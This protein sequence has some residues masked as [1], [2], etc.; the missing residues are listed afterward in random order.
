[1]TTRLKLVPMKYFLLLLITLL[2]ACD[3]SIDS[4]PLPYSADAP[5]SGAEAEDIFDYAYP[6]VLMQVTQDLMF[7][8]PFRPDSHPNQFIM[9]DELAK[10]KNQAVVLG[11]RNTLYFVGWVNLNKGLVAFEIPNMGSRTM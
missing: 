2:S 9:F 8:V 10:P 11:N 4:S 6:L 7:T 3:S 1:M 5:I